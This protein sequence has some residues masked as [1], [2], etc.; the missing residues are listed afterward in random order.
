M[1]VESTPQRKRLILYAPMIYTGGGKTLLLALLSALTSV[2]DCWGEVRLMVDARFEDIPQSNSSFKLQALIRPGPL[3]RLTAEKALRDLVKDDD[4]VFC[5]GNLPPLYR[6]KGRVVGFIQNAHLLESLPG[7][8]VTV[9]KHVER[10]W[11]KK[12]LDHC[13]T[14]IVQTQ[15]M[16]DRLLG[17]TSL[18]NS[19]VLTMPFADE[20]LA[21]RLQTLPVNFP[22]WDFG[23]VSL[24][25]QH[26]NHRRLLEAFVLLAREGLTPS[27]VVTVPEKMDPELYHLLEHIQ[28][29]EG[30][31]VTNLSAVDYSKVGK[32]YQSIR[33]LIFPSLIES[34]ALPL[35]EAQSFGLPILAPEKDYVRDVVV[36]QETFD[37]ES[38]RSILRAIKRFLNSPE[39]P[40]YIHPASELL[41][42]LSDLGNP[43][44]QDNGIPHHSDT[45][46]RPRDQ[47]C[48]VKSS[49]DNRLDN[50]K[51]Q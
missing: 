25:W 15:S 29:K 36:P 9:K 18:N 38:P 31:Q 39:K 23:Y 40:A 51:V 22:Q 50:S 44:Q 47:F 11:F 2:K 41:K 32:V 45:A 3:G 34:F 37:A 33:A 49:S 17:F 7:K 20:L 21:S 14:F 30:V 6:I 46:S 48:A 42:Q 8:S 12:C 10:W 27:L 43:C 4:V 24:P 26:K 16:R 5:L 1:K 35:L 19:K 28:E 13:Q